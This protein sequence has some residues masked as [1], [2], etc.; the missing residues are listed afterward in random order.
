MFLEIVAHS[1]NVSRRLFAIAQPDQDTLAVCR[2]GFLGFLD[3]G[4]YDDTFHEGLAVEG[5]LLFAPRFRRPSSVQPFEEWVVD[6]AIVAV[7]L[8]F[9]K[10]ASADGLCGGKKG[11]GKKGRHGKGWK[12]LHA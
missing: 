2:V 10:I 7:A 1:R 3:Q 4:L 5:M 12:P 11:R 9:L 6:E 8:D